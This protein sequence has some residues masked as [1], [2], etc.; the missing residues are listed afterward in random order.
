MKTV[1]L[2]LFGVCLISCS[3]WPLQA[4]DR[5]EGIDWQPWSEAV[6]ARAKAEKKLVLLD[7]VAVWCHWCHVMDEI[8][9]RDPA[10]VKLLREKYIAVRVDQDARP[11]ISNR[12]EDY[13]WPATVVF[14]AAG[15]EL[16]KRQG[17]LPPKPMAGMLQAFVD[18]PTPGPSVQA[19]PVIAPAEA[20]ALSD[21]QRTAMREA[22]LGAY[23]A[24]L[25]GWGDVHKYLNWDALEYCLTEGAH[26]DARMKEMARQTLTAGLR[27]VD[28]VWGGVYQY[29]TDGDW[30]HPHFEK[31]MPFQAENLRV[32]AMAATLRQE[33]KWLEPARKIHGYMRDFLRS[34]EGAFYVSQDADLVAGEHSGEYFALDDAGRR[35]RGV[36]RID[37]HLYA[38]ENGLAVTGFVALYAADGDEAVLAEARR[39]AEWVIAH[40]ALE[41][42][43]FR[44]DEKDAAGPYLADTLAM[45]RACLALYSVTAERPWLARAET[46]AQFIE[47]KFRAPLGYATAVAAPGAPF[48]PKPQVDENIAFA[49]LANLLR[50]YT[51]KD[52]WRQAAEHAMQYL[53]SPVVVKQ[54]GYGTSGILLADRELRMEPAHLTIVGHKDDA[55]AQA[56]FRTALRGAPPSSRIEW[57]DPRE[58]PL[59]HDDVPFPELPQAAAFVCAGGTCSIPMTSSEKL[60]EK[61][62]K[63]AR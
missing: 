14:D 27:L 23:D 33:P 62:A 55:A 4:A 20:G 52:E 21:A 50:H 11:D 45:G 34:P 19:E 63:L 43:G 44:H 42:G 26:G 9:Y 6:F 16:A 56:L 39:A 7:V 22:F 41:G 57:L 38:R 58:G 13:G 32:L 40:R 28:P 24:K 2:R 30:E 15:K 17:Y 61:L 47:A 25:G 29:S 54:Q 37:K 36:P 3:T 1:L 46:A 18:D 49:R 10:V 5:S 31:I 53:A 48:A 12:Y 59:P 60:A 8:T 35:A 51:G